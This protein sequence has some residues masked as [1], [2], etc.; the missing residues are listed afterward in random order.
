MAESEE[1]VIDFLQQLNNLAPRFNI[2]DLLKYISTLDKAQQDLK[3][4]RNIDLI[5]SQSLVYPPFGVPK[6]IAYV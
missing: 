4:N 2:R 5:V 1:E 3:R 6:S